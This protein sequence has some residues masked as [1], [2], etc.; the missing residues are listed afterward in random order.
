MLALSMAIISGTLTASTPGEHQAVGDA[1]KE[2]IRD[3]LNRF[4]KV[5][6][7]FSLFLSAKRG[8]DGLDA[9]VNGLHCN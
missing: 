6:E 8:T 2:F 3:T 9:K 5:G 1:E 4:K 7:D